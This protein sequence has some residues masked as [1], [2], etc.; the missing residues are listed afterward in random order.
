MNKVNNSIGFLGISLAV[1]AVVGLTVAGCFGYPA[2][3][4]YQNIQDARNAVVVSNI[5]IQNQDQLIQVENKKAEV[6]VADAKGIMES[7]KIIDSSL[8][9]NY[10]QY[11]AIQAQEDMAKGNNHTEVYIPVGTNGIPIV[12][13]VNPSGDTTKDNK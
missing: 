1:V 7:Q 12:R 11:L 5:E 3:N 9:A 8:T 10:L 2:Y 13:T 4:R 6:R